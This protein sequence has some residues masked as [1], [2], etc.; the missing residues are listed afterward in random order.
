[1]HR[2]VTDG[3]DE[4]WVRVREV[5]SIS[6]STHGDFLAG[7]GINWPMA[8]DQF[9]GLKATTSSFHLLSD[10]VAHLDKIGRI[11]YNEDYISHELLLDLSREVVFSHLFEAAVCRMNSDELS[12]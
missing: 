10:T 8:Y 3:D 4:G 1:M 12:K 6:C 11:C 7:T 9:K 5:R 2:R